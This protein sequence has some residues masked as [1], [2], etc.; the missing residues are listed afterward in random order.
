MYFSRGLDQLSAEIVVSV[1]Q[2]IELT[3]IMS[4]SLQFIGFVGYVAFPEIEN[5][6]QITKKIGSS[7]PFYS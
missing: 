3:V 7:N 5:Q 6:H 4:L 1:R 2:G